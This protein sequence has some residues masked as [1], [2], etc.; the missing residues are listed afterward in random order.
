MSAAVRL[1]IAASHDAAHR[2]GGWAFVRAG[3]D[4][5]SRAGGD[6]RTTRARTI[7]TG[8]VASL[9]DVPAGAALAVVAP[10]TDA[11][12][13]HTLLKPPAEPPA[14]DLDLRA[15]LTAALAG[16]TWTLAVSDPE[17]PTPAGFVAA[18]ADTASEKAKMGGAFTIAIP[19]T[20]L[21]K[22]KGL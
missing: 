1:W 6:R 17:A 22:V 15:V 21:A 3:G 10:R 5:V 4:T 7:L 18:W 12:I 19:K 2:N 8:F 9:K 20:N 11:L 16:K 13:L 14:E